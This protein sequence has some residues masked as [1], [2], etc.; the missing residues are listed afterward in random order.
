MYCKLLYIDR[1][2]FHIR[3]FIQFRHVEQALSIFLSVY[4]QLVSKIVER[5]KAF[6]SNIRQVFKCQ[7]NF[8]NP[9]NVLCKIQSK[10]ET[11]SIV[12]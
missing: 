1:K 7:H 8:D 4:A 6:V 9:A 3:H 5:K 10:D 2:L 11:K 12:C